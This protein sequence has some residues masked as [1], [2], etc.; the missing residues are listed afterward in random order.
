MYKP[1]LRIGLLAGLTAIV[2]CSASEGLSPAP[3]ADSKGS[4]TAVVT[5]G[6]KPQT[7][8]PVVSSF[9]LSG[10]VS[11]HEPGLDTT[12]VEP[13][14]N[15]TVTLVKI[16]DVDGDTLKPSVT[17]TSATTDGAGSFRIENLAP[18]YYRID[19]TAPVGSAY[20]DGVW[21]IG[22]ARQSEVSVYIALRR[23]P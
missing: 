1:T 13:V 3:N 5:T 14:A 15:A 19:V 4:D 9:T 20:L 23:K 16:A 10:V 7:P 12:K 2:A 22:P 8:P 18:A 17:V 6:S 21:G 11:G